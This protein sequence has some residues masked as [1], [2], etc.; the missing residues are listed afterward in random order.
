MT[1]EQLERQQQ[2]IILIQERLT[3]IRMAEEAI[4]RA[5]SELSN[6]TESAQNK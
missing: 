3:L 2:L 5:V 6:I 1:P 4:V